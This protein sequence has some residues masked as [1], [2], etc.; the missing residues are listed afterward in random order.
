MPTA[1]APA[2][3]VNKHEIDF[4]APIRYIDRRPLFSAKAS[5]ILSR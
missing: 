3:I 1:D 4:R 2:W 5:S